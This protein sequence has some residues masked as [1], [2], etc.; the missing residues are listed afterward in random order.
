MDNKEITEFI[1]DLIRRRESTDR[2][3]SLLKE[4]Y[5]LDGRKIP[6]LIKKAKEE[7]GGRE[8][9]PPFEI[10]E[11]ALLIWDIQVQRLIKT[12]RIDAVDLS[13]LCIYCIELGRYF[14]ME[15][16]LKENGY[17][18]TTHSGY[19]QQRPQVGIATT[20]LKNANSL[21]KMLALDPIT[22]T[23]LKASKSD[24]QEAAAGDVLEFAF[25]PLKM[26]K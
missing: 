20:S 19:E 3:K 22:L 9:L 23:K 17:T 12:F 7:L 10:N 21:S 4:T 15:E 5:K 2:I 25:T 18:M 6:G 26:V 24:S 16:D 13:Q 1:K 11:T 8:Y 14:D